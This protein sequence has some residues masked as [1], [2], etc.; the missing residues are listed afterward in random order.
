[1]LPGLKPSDGRLR[2]ANDIGESALTQPVGGAVF[3]D[4]DGHLAS[5]L[6]AVPLR[7]ELR[8]LAVISMTSSIVFISESFISPPP[9]LSAG[10][11][12]PA[13]LCRTAPVLVRLR[14]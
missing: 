8:I 2:H 7:A 14:S 12:P 5:E 10:L 6:Q 3:Q 9:R 4:A 11:S 13:R 1:V